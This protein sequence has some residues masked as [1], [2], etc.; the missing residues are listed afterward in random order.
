MIAVA[1]HTPLDSTRQKTHWDVSTADLV[2]LAERGFREPGNVYD[3][4]GI[5]SQNDLAKRLR[6]SL[7]LGVC[8]DEAGLQLREDT[9][10]KNRLPAQKGVS[11]LDLLIEAIQARLHISCIFW[12]VIHCNIDQGTYCSSDAPAPIVAVCLAANVCVH[13][14]TISLLDLR[15]LHCMP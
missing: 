1:A 6:T 8:D 7:R 3:V 2:A 14:D 5:Y 10:G 11:F 12:D 13:E 15:T 4:D 9:F